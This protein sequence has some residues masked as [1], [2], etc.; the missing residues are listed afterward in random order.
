MHSRVLPGFLQ[1]ARPSAGTSFLVLLQTAVIGGIGFAVHA[2]TQILYVLLPLSLLGGLAVAHAARRAP[3]RALAR[4]DDA[5]KELCVGRNDSAVRRELDLG[6]RYRGPA[7]TYNDLVGKLTQMLDVLSV[8][9]EQFSGMAQQ[10]AAATADITLQTQH[11]SDET[12]NIGQAVSSMAAAVCHVAERASAAAGHVADTDQSA[13]EGK[14]TMTNAIGAMDA[15][16]TDMGRALAVITDLG[17]QTRD[18]SMV[19]EVIN[20]LAGQTNLL[21]L[22]AAIEAARAG[23]AGRGFAV[24]A[25]EVRSLA[26]RTQ[27]S[28]ST[29]HTIIQKIVAGVGEAESVIGSSASQ[30]QQCAEVVENATITF[31]EIVGAV[32][33]LKESNSGI[34]NAA[35]SQ[36]E[37]ANS[38]HAS[39]DRI[40]AAGHASAEH[41]AAIAKYCDELARTASQLVM[42]VSQF[43]GTGAGSNAVNDDIEMF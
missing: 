24:V 19:L 4:L 39:M 28:T 8:S 10:I 34:S 5:L 30:S 15:L 2:D 9:A 29:I 33:S 38:I 14:I 18:I 22:N 1:G 41:S 27:Q 11:Q 25:D 35:Q 13:N 42:I 31:V 37:A 21:A 7:Q 6:A 40:A 16:N 3:E 20:S 36:S 23:E 43:R 12:G 32:A 26:A 17:D